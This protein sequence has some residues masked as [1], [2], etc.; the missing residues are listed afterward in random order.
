MRGV[1]D[2]RQ[3]TGFL[4]ITVFLSHIL[5]QGTFRQLD[6]LRCQVKGW[7]DGELGSK[8]R[9]FLGT[10]I[11]KMTEFVLGNELCL[12]LLTQGRKEVHSPYLLVFR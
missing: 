11:E 7:G 1:G 8:R 5:Q 3:C 12:Y 10:V 6:R 2:L 9:A 4:R